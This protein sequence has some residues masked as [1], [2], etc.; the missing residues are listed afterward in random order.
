VTQWPKFRLWRIAIADTR[1]VTVQTRTLVWRRRVWRIWTG[2]VFAWR[3]SAL[4]LWATWRLG[5]F[6]ADLALRRSGVLAACDAMR[7]L[8]RAAKNDGPES[9][10]IYALKRRLIGELLEAYPCRIRKHIQEQSCYSCDGTGIW[11]RWASYA[12]TCW[13]CGGTGVYRRTELLLFV[14]SIGGREF[15]WH[16]PADFWP[17]LNVGAPEAKYEADRSPREYVGAGLRYETLLETVARWIDTQ[18][19]GLFDVPSRPRRL[20]FW[21]CVRAD[22]NRL[23]R[24]V[25]DRIAAAHSV[26]DLPF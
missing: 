4:R 25:R 8:N 13:K 1:D 23:V 22:T 21:R 9:V 19:L 14:F 16:Q 10:E 20:R 3:R 17:A 2:D 11:S 26:D 18:G 24:S 7:T 6:G 15:R 5:L 12:D